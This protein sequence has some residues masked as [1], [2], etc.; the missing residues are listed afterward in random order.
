[1]RCTLI[2]LAPLL[3]HFD[4]GTSHYATNFLFSSRMCPFCTPPIGYPAEKGRTL[5]LG[6]LQIDCMQNI[7]SFCMYFSQ[8]IFETW[9]LPGTARFATD[10]AGLFV[11]LAFAAACFASHFVQL[12][13][14]LCVV[15]GSLS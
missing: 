9:L 5:R 2:A 15:L 6:F 10:S 4:F 7:C 13:Y 8:E 3:V 11:K 1:M 12:F 14:G